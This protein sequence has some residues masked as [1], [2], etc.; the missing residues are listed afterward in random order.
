MAQVTVTKASPEDRERLAVAFA[1]AFA[2]DPI[3][4]WLLAGKPHTDRRL[5]RFF[6]VLVRDQLRRPDDDVYLTEDGSGGAIWKGID[7][8]KTPVST[9][10]RQLPGLT[11][12]FGVTNTRPWAIL[13]AMEKVHP[14]QPHYYLE[15]LGTR[16]SAQGKGVGSAVMEGMLERCDREGVPAYLE[17][18]N[19]RNIPFYAR[20][21]FVVRDPVQLPAG[22]P[23]LTPMWR[24]PRTA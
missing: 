5:H 14:T 23:T 21:G 12:A 19:P 1:D 13:G 8:W 22:A 24:E 11:F 6:R 3:F 18:S 4:L 17:S 10:V 9:I 15:T 7:R 16:Q 20:H 2:E